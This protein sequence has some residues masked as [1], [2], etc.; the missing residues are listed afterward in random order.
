M[1]F[2]DAGLIC[3]ELV[4]SAMPVAIVFALCN[5]IVRT[6]LTAAFGGKMVL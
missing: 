6:F 5:M 3:A 1:T 2:S 4:K